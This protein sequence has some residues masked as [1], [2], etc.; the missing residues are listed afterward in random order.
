MPFIL[1]ADKP[2]LQRIAELSIKLV[3]LLVLFASI[4]LQV[5]KKDTIESV[6]D[7]ILLKISNNIS[8]IILVV[9]LMFV[10]WGLEAWKWWLLISRVEQL[11]FAKAVLAI[12]S[13]ATLTLFTPNRIGEYGGRFVFLKNPIRLAALQATLLG[14]IA[15]IW[16]TAVAGLL[17]LVFWINHTVE[18][19][20][21]EALL[22]GVAVVL[23]LAVTLLYFK[24]GIVAR[25][26]SQWPVLG[27][28]K[29]KWLSVADYSNGELVKVLL[30]ATLRYGVYLGQYILLLDAF[31]AGLPTVTAAALVATMFVFQSV[32]PSIAMFDLGI[33]GNL[34]ILVFTGFITQ[35]DAALA[36]AFTLWLINLVLPAIIGYGV[37][38]S[39]K[40]ITKQE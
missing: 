2:K 37:I 35:M 36:A 21:Y 15:Q 8:L 25:L 28:Y 17:G 10:N 4:Y 26:V 40:L 33:R 3:I 22:Y 24:L 20:Q 31:G 19:Q 38:L 5:V 39:S 16:I 30:L 7:S 9:L 14:S 29:E 23:T 18:L 11:P 13:G 27:K 6:F 1:F 34:T 12:F 32:I